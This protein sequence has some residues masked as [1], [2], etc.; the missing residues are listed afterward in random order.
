MVFIWKV[1]VSLFAQS[2]EHHQKKELLRSFHTN[3]H[4][5]PDLKVAIPKTIAWFTFCLRREGAV[6]LQQ[7]LY[8]SILM[9]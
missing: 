4:T 2:N 3:G 6:L 8:I 9:L 1:I 5:I 7:P